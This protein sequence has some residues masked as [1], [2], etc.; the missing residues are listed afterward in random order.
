MT[1]A[2]V[3]QVVRRKGLKQT[4][5]DKDGQPLPDSTLSELLGG[6]DEALFRN[7]FGL[8]HDR[9]RE[10]AE[11]LLKGGGNL[12][13]GL[14]DASVGSRAL[15]EVKEALSAEA[16][17]LY[18]ARGKTPK[19][20]VALEALREKTRRKKEA[21]LSPAAFVEQTRALTQKHEQR[22][23]ALARRREL[24]AEK[25]RVTRELQLLPLLSR[26][27]SLSVELSELTRRRAEQARGLV[28]SDLL[29]EQIRDLERR[30]GVLLSAEADL[31]Q[32]RSELSAL[33]R[34]LSAAS[35]RIGSVRLPERPIDTPLRTRLR[36]LSSE[37]T[38]AAERA[39]ALADALLAVQEELGQLAARIAQLPAQ[40]CSWLEALLATIE[41]EDVLASLSRGET[42][43]TRRGTAL[44]R[45]SAQLGLTLDTAQLSQLVLPDERALLELERSD[46]AYDAERVR[47]QTREHAIEERT[48]ALS[49]TRSRLLADGE[50]ISEATLVEARLTREQQL[51][52]LS[53][54]L[55]QA[56]RLDD[57]PQRISRYRTQVEHADQLADRMRREASRASELN[58]V[59]GELSM[60]ADELA[61]ILARKRSLATLTA[62]LART[63]A[64]LLAP[65]G[66]GLDSP[67]NL[68]P[69]LL[70][71][72]A[73]SEQAATLMADQA[74]QQRLEV[75]A[76]Q[77]TSELRAAL[78]ERAPE[79]SLPAQLSLAHAV[80]LARSWQARLREQLRDA[81]RQQEKAA[82]LRTREATLR[83]QQQLMRAERDGFARRFGEE[84]T[85]AG[86]DSTLEPDELLACL[87]DMGLSF[88][89]TR[90]I[91]ALRTREE[92]LATSAATLAA[93][94]AQ[95]VAKHVPEASDAGLAEQLEALA[96]AQRLERESERDHTRLKSELA[97]LS[98]E[99][100]RLG[101][102]EERE[103]PAPAHAGPRSQHAQG[104]PVRDRRQPE[105]AG[106]R[107]ERAR[108]AAGQA[109]CRPVHPEEL[110]VCSRHRRGGGG[111]AVQ[112]ARPPASLFAGEALALHP[113]ARGGTLSS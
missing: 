69:R 22:S 77:L 64:G 113:L 55:L 61:E 39:A 23:E 58:G 87:D 81:T 73:L 78:A 71:L 57:A 38:R 7:M 40:D 36:R 60:L 86:L 89:L 80:S 70:R 75:H 43:L 6:L 13:E 26:H 92:A 56:A 45:A 5:L 90:K 25:A 85:L 50:P 41:R 104:A 46:E 35:Q 16:D 62:E 44:G 93:D 63:L 88:E 111:R 14:F 72:Q 1:R 15:R 48:R 31:P 24:L 66:L 84:L 30:Y 51:E 42:E 94:L 108:A 102:G 12:G 96:R 52:V 49:L 68:R 91:E 47:H 83:S 32:L 9:L 65:C 99:L 53:G 20:N 28:G 37:H 3:L 34:E 21:A 100:S 2:N 11:A 76:A 106:G 19:L 107:F 74:A 82:E 103:H 101:D 10:G 112:R 18:K 27:E 79:L 59:A 105:H 98:D 29:E 54:A 8:D 4:L 109:R 110:A 33:T 17:E 97:Q 95:L 67:R